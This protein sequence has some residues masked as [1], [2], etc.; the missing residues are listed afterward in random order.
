MTYKRTLCYASQTRMK[1]AERKGYEART[2]GQPRT[3]NPYKTKRDRDNWDTGW[4]DADIETLKIAMQSEGV[5]DD[6]LPF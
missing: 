5:D 3:A 6:G 4:F 1:H 2:A